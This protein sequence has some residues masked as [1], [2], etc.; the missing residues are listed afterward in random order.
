MQAQLYND[1]LKAVGVRYIVNPELGHRGVA[2]TD[3]MRRKTTAWLAWLDETRPRMVLK[4]DPHNKDRHAVMVRALGKKVAYIDRSMAPEIRGMLKQAPHGM[5]ITTVCDVVVGQ[6]G[7]FF[8]R[9]PKLECTY[10]P[11]EAGVDWNEYHIAEP[12]LLP[13]EYFD[14]HEEL[15]MVIAEELLPDLANASV[16]ELRMYFDRWFL[17]VRYNQSREVQ[18]EMLKFISLLAA[19]TREEVRRIAIDVDHLRTK[20][21]SCEILN[22]MAGTWWPGILH[23]RMSNESFSLLR[24]RCHNY[25]SQML[26]I[27]DKTEELMRPM[28][29]E[30]YNEVGDAYEFFSHLAYLAP[31]MAAL[32]GVLS[33]LALRTLLCEELGLPTAPFFGKRVEVVSDVKQI[34]TTIGK[35]MEFAEKQC[36]EYTEVLTVQRLAEYLRQDYMGTRSEQVENIP[37]AARPAT[38]IFVEK[39]YGPCNGNIQEQ[40][41][42][43]PLPCSNPKQ[44]ETT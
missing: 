16:E 25:R 19:D 43:L 41:L 23:E 36:K 10:S 39:N 27:L 6:H 37:D 7:Y 2:E 17:S 22:E 14:S 35:V 13:S 40:K 4:A 32:S 42:Q 18:D 44:I 38:N 11:E 9:K 15:S 28:P 34:P 29:G 30:L 33:L 12:F 31:P 3:E 8:V 26:L 24:Q 21:N 20:K 5:L 1:T